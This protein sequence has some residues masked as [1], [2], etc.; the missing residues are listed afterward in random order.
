MDW[1]LTVSTF[2][3]KQGTRRRLRNPTL[4]RGHTTMGVYTHTHTHRQEWGS[5]TCCPAPATVPHPVWRAPSLN[6]PDTSDLLTGAQPAQPV[7]STPT[8]GH[9]PSP[10]NSRRNTPCPQLARQ[11]Y[12]QVCSQSCSAGAQEDPEP[13]AQGRASWGRCLALCP[14]PRQTP[15]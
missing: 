12:R 7:N 15:P 1:K 6:L 2:C 14:A 11:T 8:E 4:C 3:Q 9:T 13:R 10:R 5:E